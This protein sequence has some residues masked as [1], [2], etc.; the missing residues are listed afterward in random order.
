[1][2]RLVATILLAVGWSLLLVA[3]QVFQNPGLG[4][5]DC[6]TDPTCG[7]DERVPPIVWL[8]GLGVILVGSYLTRS[9]RDSL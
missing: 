6:Y 8:V 3:V 2:V 5:P 9:K 7:V 1:V 4:G